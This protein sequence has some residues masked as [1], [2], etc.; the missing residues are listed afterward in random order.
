[1]DLIPTFRKYLGVFSEI[2][3]VVASLERTL[4]YSFAGKTQQPKLTY[5]HLSIIPVIQTDRLHF[6][7]L[8]NI[9][10]DS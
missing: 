4:F 10:M 7:D 2:T 1:M 5:L 6:A 3:F 8:G 9:T